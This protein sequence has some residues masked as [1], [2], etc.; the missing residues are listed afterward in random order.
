M[1]EIRKLGWGFGRCNQRCK[2]CYNASK[3]HAPVYEFSQLKQVADKVCPVISDINYGTGEF[4]VNPNTT[5]LCE[6]IADIY[7]HVHQALTTNGSTVVMM[8]PEKV[9]RLFHDVDVSLDFPDEARHNEFR[10]HTRAWSWV[11]EALGILQA[12]S[13]PRSIVTCVTSQT[14]NDDI[15]GLLEIA[16]QY[17]ATWRINWFR[18]T[19]RGTADLRLTAARAW[20]VIRFLSELNVTFLTLDS[21]FAGP[22]GVECNPCPAGH[23]TCRIHEN[24]ETSCYPFL[25]GV[26]WTGGNI[27]RPEVTLDTIYASHAFERLRERKVAACVGCPFKTTCQ[28]GCVTRAA[29]HNGSISQRDDFCPIAAGLDVDALR[30]IKIKKGQCDLVHEGYLCTTICKPRGDK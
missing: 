14:N 20:E 7:P 23:H 11:H 22:L 10:Q 5:D 28:G 27:L 4:F 18:C 21:I 8:R 3:P 1:N 12:H 25:K 15:V 24:M 19:G 26:E 17:G 13:V 16:R 30:E 29:L 9:A 6:Y 2:H